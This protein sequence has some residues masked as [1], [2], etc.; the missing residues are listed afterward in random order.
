MGRM[1]AETERNFETSPTG[2]DRQEPTKPLKP[3]FTEIVRMKEE[4]KKKQEE[5]ERLAR[6]ERAAEKL[7]NRKKLKK[8]CKKNVCLSFNKFWY[9]GTRSWLYIFRC[10]HISST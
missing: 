9:V 10:G 1:T 7:E 4:L 3:K 8:K 6:E 5:E 2:F